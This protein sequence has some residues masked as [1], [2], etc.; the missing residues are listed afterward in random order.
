[1]LQEVAN[2]PSVEDMRADVDA[3]RHYYRSVLPF[4]PYLA[5]SEPQLAALDRYMVDI[6]ENPRRKKGFWAN[7]TEPFTPEDYKLVV[8]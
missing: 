2:L 6:G 1:M 7:L 3:R 8:N 5:H 4:N